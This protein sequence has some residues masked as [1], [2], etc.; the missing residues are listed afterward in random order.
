MQKEQ[1][2]QVDQGREVKKG[3]EDILSKVKI[4][5]KTFNYS[6]LKLLEIHME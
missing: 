4:I 5:E 3:N 1:E 2:D 6:Y